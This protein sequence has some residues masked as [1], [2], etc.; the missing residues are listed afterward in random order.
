MLI[1]TFY[2][3][4]D[5]NSRI[6]KIVLFLFSFALYYSVNALFF[7]DSTMHKIYID[8][9]V[10]NFIYQIPQYSTI[11]SSSINIIVKLLSLT[12]RNILE[13][14]NEKKNLDEKV[15]T[16]LKCLL[17]KFVLFFE[18]V[19]MFLLLFWYYLSCFG[20]LYKNTQMHL[21]KDTMISFLLSL[22]YPLGL[23]AI[24]GLF[25]IPALKG[26]NNK[27]KEIFYKISTY[28]QLI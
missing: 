7:T 6:I 20:A 21:F 2:T 26:P 3:K 25:R 9:G 17:I 10:F 28:L 23:N 4:S 14:K 5:Y 27:K 11:I 12:E 24:L 15:S 1:F 19:F 18:L 22:I 16:V 13:I 8:Q